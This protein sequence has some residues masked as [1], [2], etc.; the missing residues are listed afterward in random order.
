MKE[1]RNYPSHIREPQIDLTVDS[2][3]ETV[4]PRKQCDNIFKMM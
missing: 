4:Y 3:L 1:L 2:S